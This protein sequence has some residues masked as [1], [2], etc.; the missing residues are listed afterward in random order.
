MR[1]SGSGGSAPG[2]AW[3]SGSACVERCE[4]SC[5]GLAREPTGGATGPLQG[6]KVHDGEWGPWRFAVFVCDFCLWFLAVWIL[7]VRAD[8]RGL[9]CEE[10]GGQ[11]RRRREAGG[12][13]VRNVAGSGKLTVGGS[14][15]MRDFLER[16]SIGAEISLPVRM[17]LGCCEEKVLKK[18]KLGGRYMGGEG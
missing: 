17:T 9:C 18:E 8:S 2:T 14:V 1:V 6:P 4:P 11:R 3:G 13:A 12:R 7:G 5:W 16:N 10:W 15:V